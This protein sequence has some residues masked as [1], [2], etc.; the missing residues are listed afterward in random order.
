MA[1]MEDGHSLFL[2]PLSPAQGSGSIAELRMPESAL[3]PDPGVPVAAI[4]AQ[5][6]A[7]LGSSVTLLIQLP[8]TE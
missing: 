3:A 7:L 1:R 8:L 5:T 2:S 4:G 6:V